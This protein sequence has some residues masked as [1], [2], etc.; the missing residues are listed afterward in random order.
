MPSGGPP[1]MI[2]RNSMGIPTDMSCCSD[3]GLESATYVPAA[4]FLREET[5]EFPVKDQAWGG[6]CALQRMDGACCSDR[7]WQL[8]P[9][10][11]E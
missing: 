2:P 7:H 4:Q 9:L 5:W 6:G 3:G 10:D 11:V 1:S 8:L